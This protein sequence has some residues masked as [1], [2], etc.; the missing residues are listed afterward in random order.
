MENQTDQNNEASAAGENTEIFTQLPDGQV[1]ISEDVLQN[2]IAEIENLKELVETGAC[3]IEATQLKISALEDDLMGQLNGLEPSITDANLDPLPEV[4]TLELSDEEEFFDIA[5]LEDIDLGNEA[6]LESEEPSDFDQGSRDDEDEGSAL[7]S[8]AQNEITAEDLAAVEPAAGESGGGST[9]TNSGFG[10]QTAF[11]SEDLRSVEDIGP[12]DPTQLQFD[13]PEPEEDTLDAFDDS[14]EIAGPGLVDL[15]ETGN[16]TT[17]YSGSLIIDF[18][19]DGPGIVTP[20]GFFE[21][22]GSLLNGELSTGGVPIS[23]ETNIDGYVGT[24]NGQTAFIITFDQQT[25]DYTFTQNLPFDHADG[26]DSNDE[27]TIRFGVR[28]TDNDGDI[29]VTSVTINV[30]DDA[31]INLDEP[32]RV[33]SE[34]DLN[35]TTSISGAIDVDF[36]RDGAGTISGNGQL[37]PNT[38]TSKGETVSVVYDNITDTYTGVANGETVFTLD[39]NPDGS[40][41]FEL[42]Q[43][44]DHPAGSD[45]LDIQFGIQATDFDGDS[46][47]GLL[48]IQVQ[49]DVP[50]ANDDINIFNQNDNSTNGNVITGE[51]EESGGADLLSNDEGNSLT[52]ISFD[53]NTIDVPEN[54]TASIDGEYG[55][56]N[57]ASDGSYDYT[58]FDSSVAGETVHTHDIDNPGGGTGAGDI[59]NVTTSY[60]ED[61]HELTMSVV[62][63]DGANGF[64]VAI[65]DGGNPK[66]HSGEM[67][68]FY[69]DASGTEPVVSVFA[70]NGIGLNG[71]QDGSSQAGIQAPDKI[72]TSIGADS[73][74]TSVNFI[75][76]ANGNTIMSFSV[77]ATDIVNHVPNYPT[78]AEWTGASFSDNVG[79]WLHPVSGL[80]TSYDAEGYVTEWGFQG[81]SYYDSSNSSTTTTTELPDHISD[82]FQYTI[83]DGDGDSSVATLKLDGL[84]PT[85]IVGEN[86]S[87]QIGTEV[88]H[89]IGDTDSLI[90]GG[91]GEDVLIGDVGGATLEQQTQDYNIL[92]VLDTSGSMGSQSNPDSRISLLSDAVENLLDQM[93]GYQDGQVKVHLSTFATNANGG[94]TFTIT[95]ADDLANAIQ[96][97]Q[98]LQASGATN[99][100][101]GLQSGIS[102]LQ[103]GEPING[104]ETITY[105]ISDGRPNTHIGADGDVV[106]SWDGTASTEL[107]GS[108]GTDE[109]SLIQGLS[110]DVIAVNLGGPDTIINLNA[111][112]T[113]GQAINVEDSADLSS[114]LTDTNPILRLASA[115][116]DVIQGGDGDDVI[117]GDAVNTDDLNDTHNLGDEEG[118]SFATFDS[119]ENGESTLQPDWD[120]EDTLEYI[121]ENADALAEETETDGGETRGGGDDV[122]YGG[123][124]DDQIFGQEGDDILYG[125]AGNDVLHGGSGADTF[126]FDA[127]AQ[128]V[129]VIS[130]FNTGEG[131]VIDL[132]SVIQNYDATQ[133]AID[134]FVFVKEVAGGS[135]L[136]LDVTG[137]GDV[138]NAVNLVA[139]EGVHDTSVQDLFEGGNINVF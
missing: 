18:G 56:L 33:V 114:L 48:T 69:Y 54:G 55:T 19:E 64:S 6:L 87:D 66:G 102:W 117:F 36:G 124:G 35:T 115:G 119:L 85:L 89:H 74:F 1:V 93:G 38:L 113:D 86:V 110:D 105:V 81:R 22:T 17:T 126:A 72:A 32:V 128:G 132:S 138:S 7:P 5:E 25:G 106:Y 4:V 118:Q 14:P 108:D 125:G 103:G 8:I 46:V 109:I 107:S 16:G 15:D 50:V 80:E 139:L 42:A 67:A 26:T 91:D 44:L 29:A 120:R 96:Y 68:M 77:D 75:K 62:I 112:D 79:L 52:Q 129:D 88:Q 11:T 134:D 34:D 131:D 94:E 40:Y 133:Q 59:K 111:I 98:G 104:A 2:M 97:V 43:Q 27:I 10:F 84:E 49:D 130:D 137:S 82:E 95:N 13:R 9:A 51:G 39:I 78:A 24:A 122:L 58:L 28:A 41:N 53:G 127:I 101:A 65:N 61:T 30:L 31:P 12:I 57:I 3:D 123:A 37:T 20:S 60:N 83:T 23:I 76:D 70:Y 71:Y 47:D 45:V 136:S 90:A 21:I 135:I 63:E 121:E 92:F 99:Y 73:P 100:E 116:D